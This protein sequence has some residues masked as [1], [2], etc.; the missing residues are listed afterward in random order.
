[1]NQTKTIVN[2][3]AMLAFMLALEVVLDRMTQISLLDKQYN[4]GFLPIAVTAFAWGPTSAMIVAALGDVIGALLFPTGAFFP[5]FTVTAALCGLIYGVF[6]KHSNGYLLLRIAF[7]VIC[8]LLLNWTLNSL[9]LSI[10]Y[11]SA[12]RSYTGWL[13]LRSWSYLIEMPLQFV[14]ISL[15]LKAIE[16]MPAGMRRRFFMER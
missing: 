11:S 10:L 9:W 12:G 6:L 1:M 7:A 16:R 13:A 15:V 3:I 4:L 14:M 5:G 2:R 8:S